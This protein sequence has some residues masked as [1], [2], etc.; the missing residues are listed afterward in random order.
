MH[1]N[2][3]RPNESFAAYK[4]RRREQNRAYKIRLAGHYIHISKPLVNVQHPVTGAI[5]TVVS[6][7]R[8][9]TY[10]RS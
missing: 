3:R 2:A 7:A 1:V 8:G 9:V 5:T 4:I 10:R 6:P